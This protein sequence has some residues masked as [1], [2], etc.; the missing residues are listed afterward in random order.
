MGTIYGSGPL[1]VSLNDDWEGE[2]IEMS[3]EG[4]SQFFSVAEFP[5]RPCNTDFG[6]FIGLGIKILISKLV[7]Y[8][9]V[10]GAEHHV[11]TINPYLH[12][13]VSFT[14]LR[15][16]ITITEHPSELAPKHDRS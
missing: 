7:S 11:R 6:H 15:R 4:H 12:S 5:V 10:D 2:K 13:L 14:V 1:T 16:D 8:S 9:L 3:Q